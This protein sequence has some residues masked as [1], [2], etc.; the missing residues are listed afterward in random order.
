MLNGRVIEKGGKIPLTGVHVFVDSE[1][2]TVTDADGLFELVLPY[3]N[4]QLHARFI[5]YEDYLLKLDCSAP[6]QV[7]DIALK[8]ANQ[9]L[10]DVVI[11]AGKATNRRSDV[12][13]SMEVIK[14]DLIEIVPVTNMEE[15]MRIIPG[16]N[17]AD[18]QVSI[19]SGAG[20]S[21]GAG[22]RVMVL[23]DGMPLLSAD[24][25]DVKWTFLPLENLEQ[26]EVIKGASSS[27][28]G[29]SALNGIIHFIPAWPTP[30]P[31]TKLSYMQ[32]FYLAPARS[33][34][35]WW[36][37]ETLTYQSLSLSDSRQINRVDLISEL[38]YFSDEGY[39]TFNNQERLNAHV[40]FRYRPQK[41]EGLMLGA[42]FLFSDQSSR[43]FF[44]WKNAQ[45][46]IFQQDSANATLTHSTRFTIDPFVNYHYRN[47]QHSLKARLFY[48][49]N[50]IS[51]NSMDNE[52]NSVFMEYLS[53]R[54]F[55][56]GTRWVS[57]IHF[58]N[59][60]ILSRLYDNHHSANLAFFSQWEQLFFERLRVT[61]GLR[62]EMFKLDRDREISNP[63]GRIGI[64]YLLLPGG[65]LRASFG[66][67]FR[68][69]T[70]AEKFTRTQ[71]SG[72]LVMPNPHILP[73][74]GWN[75]EI[76]Y[77]QEFP[78][79]QGAGY[80]DV[81]A[82][83]TQYHQMMEYSFGVVDSVTYLPIYDIAQMGF[84]PLGFQ[85]Q[86]VGEARI[87]GFEITSGATGSWGDFS[88]QGLAGYTYTLPVDLNTDSTYLVQ[89]SDETSI[90]KYRFKHA[91]N[92]S[93]QLS[94]RSFSLGYTL[95]YNSHIE[96]IDRFF[97]LGLV[98]P[99]LAE[100]RDENRH[101]NLI[102][103]L[104][105]SYRWTDRLEVSVILKNLANREYMIRPG[106]IGPPRNLMIKVSAML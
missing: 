75:L 73:E 92:F 89:K 8:P 1:T 25:G 49:R 74:S 12:V 79:G 51:D 96:A 15:A 98:L 84:H 103:D 78:L 13:I 33:E 11:S 32:G 4:Y 97:E 56:P 64:N 90:L 61:A 60:N 81:A 105:A 95:V 91:I 20:Y 72:L 59:A 14:P 48:N 35:Q 55:K 34:T 94:F 106:D 23:F 29:S 70:V 22:S 80:V 44:F 102:M 52:F 27:L 26:V 42:G 3:G 28:Y 41:I 67:G 62:V 7:L 38:S 10:S 6:N 53:T 58:T 46:G 31:E 45:E 24:A 93:S 5:G 69:P 71:L 18:G 68:Y 57:G 16:V 17:V 82:F 85:S 39:R 101:G 77:R 83:Q 86:N 63:L 37:N 2:G 100:Y 88:W 21:Y 99:G 87:N 47:W 54:T 40:K 66:Q 36:G 19:R 65:N 50:D 43:E 30:N 9:Q 76:G 104:S